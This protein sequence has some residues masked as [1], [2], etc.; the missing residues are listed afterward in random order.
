MILRELSGAKS[1]VARSVWEGRR[2]EMLF[3]RS[4]RAGVGK[5][6]RH[7]RHLAT[8]NGRIKRTG[9]RELFV[10]ERHTLHC[11][12]IST[13][14]LAAWGCVPRTNCKYSCRVLV[15]ACVS[16]QR[17]RNSHSPVHGNLHG[18]DAPIFRT[19]LPTGPDPSL[20]ID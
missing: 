1:L 2:F 13:E 12:H 19:T 9:E 16:V 3:K 17:A 10:L 6:V 18:T 4:R 8:A 14:S 7:S 15:R 20:V 5:G 11:D